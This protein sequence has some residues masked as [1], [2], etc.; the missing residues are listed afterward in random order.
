MVSAMV[1]LLQVFTPTWKTTRLTSLLRGMLCSQCR[2]SS[3]VMPENNDVLAV[4]SREHQV[5]LDTGDHG[6][7][8]KDVGD[9]E[10]D[11]ALCQLLTGGCKLSPLSCSR[12]GESAR[13]LPVL[14]QTSL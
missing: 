11:S 7:S 5:R 9:A 4:A 1:V 3:I 14:R 10:A 13:S 6:V 8:N 2:T 12:Q